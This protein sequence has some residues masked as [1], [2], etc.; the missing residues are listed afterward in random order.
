VVVWSNRVFKSSK[1]H[2]Q[3]PSSLNIIHGYLHTY[4]LAVT[5]TSIL[6]V[7][8]PAELAYI[9]LPEIALYSNSPY[10]SVDSKF[11]LFDRSLLAATSLRTAEIGPKIKS[12]IRRIY[13]FLEQKWSWSKRT[14]TSHIQS[15]ENLYESFGIILGEW[16]QV[17][18]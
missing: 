14:F 16:T 6:T 17:L 3:R 9:K 13:F 18:G 15:L 2:F 4:S 5:I 8:S 7:S 1:I 11:L 10:G 12:H